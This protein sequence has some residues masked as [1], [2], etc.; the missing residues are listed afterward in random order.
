MKYLNKNKKTFWF[1]K[2]IRLNSILAVSKFLMVKV[3]GPNHNKDAGKFCKN[4][5][6]IIH[7]FGENIGAAILLVFGI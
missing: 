6:D 2:T 7:L 3:Y 4:I 1:Y 5:R